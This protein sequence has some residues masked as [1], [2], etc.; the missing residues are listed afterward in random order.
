MVVLAE[1][2][3]VAWIAAF[4]PVRTT[5]EPERSAGVAGADRC[6]VGWLASRETVAL[7]FHDGARRAFPGQRVDCRWKDSAYTHSHLDPA[8]VGLAAKGRGLSLV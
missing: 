8:E 2:T 4:V 6:I 7:I 1:G 3:L 5:V